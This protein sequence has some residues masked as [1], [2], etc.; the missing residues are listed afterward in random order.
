MVF[1]GTGQEEAAQDFLNWLYKPENYTKLRET[2]GFLPAVD[3]LTVDYGSNADAFEIYN[4]E[5]AGTAP[6]ASQI[7]QLELSYEVKG[8]AIEGDPLRDETVKYLNDEQDVEPR[9]RPSLPR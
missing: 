9:S 5:I 7:K 8:Q 1:E 3:G 2:S 4:E 6:I